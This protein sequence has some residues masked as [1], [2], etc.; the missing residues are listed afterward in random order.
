MIRYKENNVKQDIFS[1]LKIK[2][3]IYNIEVE[4]KIRIIK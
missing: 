1:H 2:S 3:H 4:L